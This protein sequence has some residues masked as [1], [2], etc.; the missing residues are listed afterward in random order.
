MYFGEL[1]EGLSPQITKKVVSANRKSTNSYIFVKSAN[2][3]YYSSPQICGFAI[4][5]TYLQTAH[6][7]I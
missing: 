7:S 5:G 6:L 2:L 1:S 3:K 4:C